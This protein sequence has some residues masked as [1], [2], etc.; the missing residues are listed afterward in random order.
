MDIESSEKEKTIDDRFFLAGGMRSFPFEHTFSDLL[1][2]FEVESWLVSPNVFEPL[3]L[4]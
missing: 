2:R 3:V 4:L 1:E